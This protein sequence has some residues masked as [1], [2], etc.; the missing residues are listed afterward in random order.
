MK[1]DT[2]NT[3]TKT[4]KPKGSASFPLN[5]SRF[6]IVERLG[7][8]GMGEV[9]LAHQEKPTKRKVA[10]KVIKP[11]MGS[12]DVLARFES[13]QQALA[14]MNHPHIAHV[15]ESGLTQQKHPFFAMEYVPGLPITEFCDK[16]KLTIPERLNIF[17][18]VCDAVQHAHHKGIIHRDLKP[19]NILVAS[20]DGKY[21]PKV[22]DFGV[23]K[24]ITGQSLTEKTLHTIQGFVVGTPV[25]MSPE[26]AD[27]TGY[28]VDMRSDVYSLGILLYEL[29]TGTVPLDEEKIRKTSLLESLRII[30]ESELIKPSTK[31]NLLGE[32]T[33][34]TAKR[35]GM[36]GHSLKKLVQGDLDWIVMKAIEKDCRRRYNSPVDLAEDLRRFLEHEPVSARSP[37]FTYKAR[38]FLRRNRKKVAVFGSFFIFLGLVTASILAFNYYKKTSLSPRKI[39]PWMIQGVFYKD[40]LIEGSLQV[41]PSKKITHVESIQFSSKEKFYNA[42][43]EVWDKKKTSYFPDWLKPQS[44]WLKTGQ[45]GLGIYFKIDT[46]NPIKKVGFIVFH[47]SFGARRA[48]FDIEI[49]DNFT[50]RENVLFYS[51][52]I[53]MHTDADSLSNFLGLIKI[54]KIRVNFTYH[55]ISNLDSYST[56]FMIEDGLWEFD[57]IYNEKNL[58][59]LQSYVNQGGNLVILADYFYRGTTDIANKI[60]NEYGLEFGPSNDLTI[61]EEDFTKD[62]IKKHIITDKI[63]LLKFPNPA[64]IKVIDNS[65]A[66]LLVTIP[67]DKNL[68][69]IALYEDKGRVIV[70]GESLL[71]SFTN[72]PYPYDNARLLENLMRLE[73]VK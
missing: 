32:K 68:G 16:H 48:D 26:Q 21:V 66:K 9:F 22:I 13:E 49:I 11:G 57:K 17:M 23:A 28:N 70:I 41:I 67:G 14:L 59:A 20:R 44:E 39:Q 64:L 71:L 24:A 40:S 18:Q 52:P 43:M 1:K 4:L 47:T 35:R 69:L 50:T 27:L 25:Y 46:S 37:S 72:Y 56:V 61:F 10:L 19:S 53:D 33:D 54:M 29:L 55:F 3:K 73:K 51:S 65:N 60:L 31:L 45:K 12:M 62:C 2:N 63:K 6:K 42:E 15:Y 7:E 30:R 36:T 5:I 8:G 38:K 58:K 34:V